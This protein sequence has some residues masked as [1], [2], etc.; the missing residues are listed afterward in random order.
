MV[1]SQRWM[2]RTVQSPCKSGGLANDSIFP[3][4]GVYDM[5]KAMDVKLDKSGRIVVPKVLRDR[6]GLTT[7][8]ASA[9]GCQHLLVLC[10]P[11][12]PLSPNLINI[13]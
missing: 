9:F 4:L 11:G 8:K 7:T 6:L 12:P 2:R 13:Y 5:I 3:F 10:L 1:L